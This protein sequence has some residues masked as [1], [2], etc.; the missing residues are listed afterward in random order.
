VTPLYL[1]FVDLWDGVQILQAVM[2][3]GEW[4]D[5]RFAVRRRVT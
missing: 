5:P 1:R 4:Q 2:Q 3:S